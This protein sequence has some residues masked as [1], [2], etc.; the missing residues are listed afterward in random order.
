MS[1]LAPPGV[2]FVLYEGL[3]WLPHFNPDLDSSEAPE[4]LPQE[5]KELRREVG[6]ADGLVICSPEY[7]HGVAGSL[8]N[9]LDWLVGG[10][11]FYAKPVA[12]I[13][14]APRA[15]HSDAQLREILAT[16]AAR[17]VAEA[18]I[19]APISGVGRS[20]DAKAIA[21][22]P[23]LSRLLKEAMRAFAD[24]IAPGSDA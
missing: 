17:L 16:M 5:V 8:K 19:T 11:E 1:M 4:L 13:N 7:A 2:E 3:G 15:V 6:L 14:A 21:S 10:A 22:D 18:S 20:L 23:E 24:A 9:A 12:L